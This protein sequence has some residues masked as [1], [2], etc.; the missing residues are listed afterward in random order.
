MAYKCEDCKRIFSTPGLEKT[1]YEAYYGVSSL[2]NGS[3]ECSLEVCPCCGSEYYD[4]IEDYTF[5]VLNVRPDKKSEGCFVDF[6]VYE[7][8]GELL[9]YVC[10]LYFD[11]LLDED[12][13]GDYVDD[14]IRDNFD[15]DY[16]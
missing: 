11:I 7:A 16:D 2:F 12:S 5:E 3:H 14:Y 9:E 15:F 13:A 10:D 4:E 6:N 8:D 1:T